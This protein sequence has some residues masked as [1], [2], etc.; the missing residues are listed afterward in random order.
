MNYSPP[1]DPGTE[2]GV[3][4]CT[5]LGSKVVQL[6]AVRLAPPS[7]RLSFV[8]ESPETDNGLLSVHAG[9]VEETNL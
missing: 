4:V 5:R 1:E 9:V 3:L 7:T 6:S 8:F 2:P